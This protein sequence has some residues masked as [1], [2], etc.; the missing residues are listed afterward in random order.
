M[1]IPQ[2]ALSIAHSLEVKCAEL[3]NVRALLEEQA[4]KLERAEL[5]LKQTREALHAEIEVR[6]G[7]DAESEKNKAQIR[8]LQQT[9]S[10]QHVI[11]RDRDAAL[12]Q[13]DE[14]AQ[15]A[16]ADSVKLA[17]E[18]RN[19]ERQ[20]AANAHDFEQLL[21]QQATAN[22]QVAQ[23][24]AENEALREEVQKLLQREAQLSHALRSKDGELAEILASYQMCVQE[25]DAA[26]QQ[27][28]SLAADANNLRGAIAMRE[29]RVAELQ[30]E[31]SVL[32]QREENLMTDI[33]AC[34]YENGLLHRKVVQAETSQQHLEAA[35]GDLEQQLQAQRRVTAQF[36][37]AQAEL[38]KQ[39]I[40]K[41]NEVVFL[42]KRCEVVEHELTML[43]T[44]HAVDS[45]K[46]RE[47]DEANARLTVSGLMNQ[48]N[49]GNNNNNN[50]NNNNQSSSPANHNNNNNLSMAESQAREA[51][52]IRESLDELAQR[53]GSLAKQVEVKEGTIAQ[54]QQQ[55]SEERHNVGLLRGALSE[56]AV[57]LEEAMRNREKLQA[58][59]QEQANNLARHA[60]QGGAGAS[61]DTE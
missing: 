14:R 55:L 61:D 24:S 34:D 5:A 44:A 27:L 42:K 12:G 19:W 56:K 36:E 46:I 32:H 58:L 4:L 41:D 50:H 6:K 1:T 52:K 2:D 29:E 33:Q 54:L 3:D 28:R 30:R 25:K 20:L 23:A 31:M 35:V 59:L 57:Q 26:D 15:M 7:L 47:L 10:Q 21:A 9:V 18:R 45:R 51:A 53:N 16:L 40:R 17:Q 48:L 43:Q 11:M 37:H 22:Q 39:L 8:T 38:H 49:Y 60:Q 13:A